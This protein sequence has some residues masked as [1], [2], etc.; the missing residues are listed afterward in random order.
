MRTLNL[1]IAVLTVSFLAVYALTATSALAA[2]PG[3]P[4]PQN[5]AWGNG[6]NMVCLPEPEQTGVGYKLSCYVPDMGP[7]GTTRPA[8][9]NSEIMRDMYREKYEPP[10][11][12]N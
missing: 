8:R 9:S 6:S 1:S 12:K 7:R 4:Q 10:F 11:W 2:S 3:G 5:P